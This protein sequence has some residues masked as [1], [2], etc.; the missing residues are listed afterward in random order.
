MVSY[1][2]SPASFSCSQLIFLLQFRIGAGILLSNLALFS[3]EDLYALYI[4]IGNRFLLY[5]P[6]PTEKNVHMGIS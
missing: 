3:F 2:F 6:P 5:A 4:L 1:L